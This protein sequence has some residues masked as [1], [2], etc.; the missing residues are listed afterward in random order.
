[1]CISASWVS[2]MVIMMLVVILKGRDFRGEAKYKNSP[3]ERRAYGDIIQPQQAE[4]M[5]KLY[6]NAMHDRVT[7]KGHTRN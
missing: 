6:F 7:R 2:L 3:V 4:I 1:M 5:H